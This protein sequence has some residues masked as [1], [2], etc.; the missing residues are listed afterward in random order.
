MGSFLVVVFMMRRR[1]LPVQS[2]DA[3]DEVRE[4]MDKL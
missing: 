2:T 3:L 4:E 1:A